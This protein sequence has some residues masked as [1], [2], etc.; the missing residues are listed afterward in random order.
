MILFE[1]LY[2]V[3]LWLVGMVFVVGNFILI[4]DDFEDVFEGEVGEFGEMSID[5]YVSIDCG[6][7]W[8]FV[9]IVV[10]GGKVVFYDG[11]SFVWELELGL[12]D[13]GNFVCYFVDEWMGSDDD[14]N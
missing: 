8:E 7:F 2:V 5:L 14:Y 11:N 9:S 3:G 6:E 1:F 12:D 10:M 13:D 4:F